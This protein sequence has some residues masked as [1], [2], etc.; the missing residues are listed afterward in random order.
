MLAWASVLLLAGAVHF[1]GHS[2]SQIFATAQDSSVLRP[3]NLRDYESAIGLRRR[4]EEDF[5]DHA[6]A[7]KTGVKL[8]N[9]A[10]ESFSLQIDVKLGDGNP[11]PS[12]SQPLLG[13]SQ[14]LGSSC[15][16][17]PIVGLEGAS[18]ITPTASPGSGDTPTTCKPPG[19]TGICQG[20]SKSC[21]GGT[22]ISGYC[23]G[24]NSIRCCPDASTSAPSPTTCNH[25]EKMVYAKA[26]AVRALGGLISRGT[27]PE[28]RPS[29]AA[30]V[31]TLRQ[32]RALLQGRRGSVRIRLPRAPV[33]HTSVAIVPAIIRSS[34]ALMSRQRQLAAAAVV[35]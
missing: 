12:W 1:Q 25:Q 17:L 2:R 8:E 3:I 4:A 35:R 18:R 9:K 32:K 33:E 24:D 27:V 14:P 30:L 22:Y 29:S 26:Q 6:G 19:K 20:T 31:P 5:S 21:A 28:T 15:I 23:P 7:S 10:D 13:F 16:P 11:K 34:A